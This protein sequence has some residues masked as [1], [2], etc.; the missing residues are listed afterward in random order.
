MRSC[1]LKR[2][3]AVLIPSLP[4]VITQPLKPYLILGVGGTAASVLWKVPDPPR[5]LLGARDGGPDPGHSG[6]W[7]SCEKYGLAFVLFPEGSSAP[8]FKGPHLDTV[9]FTLAPGPSGPCLSPPDPSPAPFFLMLIRTCLPVKASGSHFLLEVSL[10]VP[11]L[12]SS[13]EAASI[14]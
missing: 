12:P 7:L 9:M 10:P 2:G 6:R 1:L 4:L 13:D 11:L 14:S 5:C 3:W 8:T